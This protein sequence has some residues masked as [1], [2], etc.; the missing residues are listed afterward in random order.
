MYRPQKSH[1][2]TCCT[3]LTMGAQAKRQSIN[4]QA[5]CSL[6]QVSYVAA[7]GL[8][9]VTVYRTQ[10]YVPT[11]SASSCAASTGVEV[12]HAVAEPLCYLATCHHS[13]HGEAIAYRLAQRDHVWHHT[14]CLKGPEVAAYAAKACLH[15][16]SSSCHGFLVYK[17]FQGRWWAGRIRHHVWFCPLPSPEQ[18]ML[19]QTP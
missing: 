13:A 16:Q 5:Y 19:E 12:L 2:S 15:L 1:C 14:L 3:S 4:C 10:T 11:C 8:L 18:P 9:A 17:L 7:K 6:A